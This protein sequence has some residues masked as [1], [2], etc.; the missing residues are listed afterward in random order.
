[1]DTPDDKIAYR[2]HI[3]TDQGN[4]GAYCSNCH[5]DLTARHPLYKIPNLQ[6]NHCTGCGYK[7]IEG[8]LY[9]QSGGSDF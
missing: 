3:V 8:G 6:N 5:T 9:I 4:G 7:I 1:M 2:E